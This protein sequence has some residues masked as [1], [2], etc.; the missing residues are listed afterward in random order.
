MQGL[1]ITT[2]KILCKLSSQ[3]ILFPTMTAESTS[4]DTSHSKGIVK[5]QSTRH[6]CYQMVSHGVLKCIQMEM[7]KMLTETI[8]QFSSKCTKARQW[9]SQ[10]SL[11]STSIELKWFLTEVVIKRSPESINPSLKSENVGATIDSIALTNLSQRAIC[12]QTQKT[13]FS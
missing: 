4:W 3:V 11:R 8:S 9:C 1:Q 13:A 2:S 6:H 7:D 10:Q 12:L 5:I